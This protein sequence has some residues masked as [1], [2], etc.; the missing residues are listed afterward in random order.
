MLGHFA[1]S[2]NKLD[3]KEQLEL[4]IDLEQSANDDKPID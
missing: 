1:N 2:W 3:N 4:P